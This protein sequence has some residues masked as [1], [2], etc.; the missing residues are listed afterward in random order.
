MTDE[1][2][3]G[4]PAPAE[5]NSDALSPAAATQNN[6]ISVQMPEAEPVKAE[7]PISASDAIKAAQEKLAAKEE[8]EKPKPEKVRA[9]DGKFAAKEQPVPKEAKAPEAQAKAAPEPRVEPA[10]SEGRVS[11]YEAPA[12]F[13]DQGKAD[14]ANAP[15]SVQAE[16]HRT[17][18]N[19]EDGYAKHKESAE[20]WEQVRQFDDMARQNGR[21][22][23]H[24]SLREIVDFEQ[25]ILRNPI[26]GF[27]KVAKHFNLNLQAIA[28]HIMGQNPD[29]HVQAIH[30][31]NQELKQH[32]ALMQRMNEMPNVLVEFKNQEGRE[33]FD[34]LQEDIMFFLKNIVKEGNP[35]ER[36]AAAYE[37]AAR[38]R[39]ANASS[40]PAAPQ[41]SPAAEA[42]PAPRPANPAGQK[43]ISGAPSSGIPSGGKKRV[44][45]NSEA[46]KAALAQAS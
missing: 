20:R 28:A 8:A 6:P 24:D 19:L 22:G 31:E 16:V 45:S 25:A 37:M 36:L 15:E 34:E 17:I 46:L 7:K 18:K 1:A 3:G 38:F 44:L 11:R 12:R 35:S 30:R 4:A 5:T 14:W 39:P 43:S 2:L 21:Q 9:D 27:E 29:Q 33:R 40:A 42:S 32:I 41:A 13:N 10:Q 26:E 23:I